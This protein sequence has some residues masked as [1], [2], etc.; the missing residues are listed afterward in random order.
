MNA[1]CFH[2]GLPVPGEATWHVAI[3]GI[4]RAMCCPGC[5]AVARTIVDIGQAGYYRARTGFAATGTAADLVPQELKLY[6]SD[7][8]FAAAAGDIEAVLLVDGMRCAACVWL[9]EHRLLALD[10]VVAASLNVATERLTVRWQGGKVQISDLLQAL[11]GIGYMAYP[12]DAA[13]HTAQLRKASRTL[14]RQLFVAGL[15]MMQVMMYV[16]PEYM[17]GDGTLEPDM[18]ALMRWASLLLTVP[19]VVYSAQ[20]FFAGAWTSLRARVLG[21]DVPVALGIGAGFLGSVVATWRGTGDVYFDSVTMF[22][23][24]LLASRWL[25]LLARRKAA[26]ALERMQHALPAVATRLAAWPGRAASVMPAAALREGDYV[27]VKPGEAFAADGILVEGRTAVDLALLTGESAPQ[28]KGPG[29]AVPGGAVNVSAAVVLHVTRP[30]AD[31][32]LSNLL[33]LVER[34]GAAKPQIAQWADRTAARFVLALLLF[35]ASTF[36]FWSWSDPARAWPV[37]IAV[38]VVSCPCALSL[39]TPSAL[40]AATDR[41]LAKG[42]LVVRPHVLETLQRATHIVFDKTGTLTA[43]RP[44]VQ[45]VHVFGGIDAQAATQ[46]AAALEA[47]SLHPLAR[48]IVA[49]AVRPVSMP[50]AQLEETPGQGLAGVVDGQAY[51]LGNA[52]YAA[53][54]AGTPPPKVDDGDGTTLVWLAG[55]GHW[56]ACFAISDALRPDAR[57]TVDWFRAH[58]KEVVLLSGDRQQLA[59]AVARQLGIDKALGDCLPERKLDYVQRLQRDGAVV[60][61]VGDGIN[62]A[63]VLSAADVSFAMGSGA[64]LAQVHAD[65]VLLHGDVG[66]VREAAAMAGATARVIRQNLAWACLYNLVAIPAAAFGLLGPWLAGVGMAASSAIV[67]VNALRLR[68]E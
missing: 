19:A 27:A 32:T 65:T 17:A 33:K 60:A 10:G 7:P 25:E 31:S 8:R 2:C 23:F 61:M 1:P 67:I 68:R 58:G 28:A 6:D 14:G 50:A 36:A 46:I 21:M 22:I 39:A 37:A 35:A 30:V 48:A 40:A 34:A 26:G 59:D 9:I 18:A 55:A 66:L 64:A 56:L 47:H 57:A 13:R 20:P 62:D 12:Y 38:L 16:A 52:R 45:A 29:D 3:D 42:I 4:D 43:G 49:H 63:A 15:C 51:R 44:A 5:E 41:L 11:R 24:L 53:G 54:L